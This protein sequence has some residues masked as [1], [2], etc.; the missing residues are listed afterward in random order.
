MCRVR[1][2]NAKRTAQTLFIVS[3][4]FIFGSKSIFKSEERE[5]RKKK[6]IELFLEKNKKPIQF[7]P[8]FFAGVCFIFR[9]AEGGGE[10]EEREEE[11]NKP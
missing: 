6:W 4:F 9:E 10:K 5:I 1:C 2:A 8:S 3:F 11:R 7:S